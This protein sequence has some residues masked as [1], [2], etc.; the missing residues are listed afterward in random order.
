MYAKVLLEDGREVTIFRDL[1]KRGWYLQT[2]D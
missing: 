2:Y 1:V